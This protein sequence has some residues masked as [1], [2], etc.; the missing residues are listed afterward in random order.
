MKMIETLTLAALEA[1]KHCS[2]WRFQETE[3]C[4]DKA[5]LLAVCTVH[6]EINPPDPDILYCVS[7]E[8]AVGIYSSPEESIEWLFIPRFPRGADEPI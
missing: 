1:A 5:S 3:E 8:G 6:D 4:H 2:N 7:A